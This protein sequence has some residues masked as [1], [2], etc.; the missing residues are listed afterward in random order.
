M[1]YTCKCNHDFQDNQYGKNVRIYNPTSKKYPDGTQE[2][3]CT[4]CG[5][6]IRVKDG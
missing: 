1:K 5:T 3:R 6:V 4:V 2:F